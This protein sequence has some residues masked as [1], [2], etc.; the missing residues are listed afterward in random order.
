MT[1]STFRYASADDL[2]K[3]FPEYS[4]YRTTKLLQDGWT[5]LA[6][7]VWEYNNFGGTISD[8]WFDDTKGTEESGSPDN[9]GEWYYNPSNDDLQIQVTESGKS[10]SADIIVQVGIDNINQSLTDASMELSSMLDA[11]FPRPIQK[12][13]QDHQDKSLATIQ[14]EYDYLVIR[15][16]C[17]ICAKNLIKAVDVNSELASGYW[18]EVTNAEGTGIVDKLNSGEYKL[19]FEIDAN[20]KSGII[21][22]PNTNTAGSIQL[23]ET[24]G[25]YVGNLYDRIKIT[26]TQAGAYGVAKVSVKTLNGEKLEGNVVTDIVVTGGFQYLGGIYCRFEG[27]TSMESGHHWYVDVRSSHSKTTNSNAYSIK[28]VRK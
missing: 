28:A 23:V 5:N 25:E 24:Y 21:S 13:F 27:S 7:D 19:S 11:R 14:M 4:N 8:V 18:S 1:Y 3:V 16:T 17:L 15:A 9:A 20:D 6:G 2:F 26:C 12:T 10:P 22:N